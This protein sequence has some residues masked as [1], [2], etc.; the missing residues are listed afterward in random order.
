KK[1]GGSGVGGFGGGGAWSGGEKASE[2]EWC[3]ESERSGDLEYL[4]VRRKNPA[5]RVFRWRPCGGR[6]RLTGG[7]SGMVV[8]S[9]VV[10]AVGYGG[11]GGCGAG[12]GVNG[13]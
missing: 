10:V 13:E 11:S 12:G 7:G 9:G 3:R 5:G 4:W 6:R 8:A 2:G 1:Y